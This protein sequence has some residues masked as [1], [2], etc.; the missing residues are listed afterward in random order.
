[1]P[2]Y[3]KNKISGLW[4]VRFREASA[5]D[6]AAHQRRLS[7]FKTKK[8][9]Q[10][11]YEDYLA[12]Q[13]QKESA[14]KATEPDTTDMMFSELVQK[15]LVFEK[16]RI[17]ESSFYDLTKKIGNKI[18]PYFGCLNVNEITPVKILEWQ[19]TL[20][21]Y[22]YRYQKDIR[23]HLCSIFN[24]AEKYYDVRNVMKKVDRPRNLEGKKEMLFWSPEEAMTCISHIPKEDYAALI[25]FLYI[26][27]CRRGEALALTWKDIDFSK[28]E[29]KISKSV[30]FKV[31]KNG[32]SYDITT[33]KNAGSNRSIYLPSFFLEELKEYKDWQKR[34]CVATTFV[35]G[36]SDPLPPTTIERIMTKAAND[37][38]VK[39]IRIHDL[40]H[41]CASFLIHKGV[42]IVAVSRRLGHTS[43]EQTLN[44]YSHM[45]PD[46]QTII[47][48]TLDTLKDVCTNKN[49]VTL[50]TE[51][52]GE[53]SVKF[54][55]GF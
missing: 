44:T 26:S 27:G 6:G 48:N 40:R 46:D 35:F 43:I 54:D 51:N 50:G 52:T 2:S 31:G 18:L 37:S 32:K 1:M 41:S 34:N 20:T 14:P 19:G 38:G 13:K 29:V 49:A 7:G 47:L 24:F 53:K 25:K 55:C 15:F 45:M 12:A 3:E 9:A 22:S 33:P 42:S 5:V 28:G 36:G 4:S 39:R 21:K 30:A 17:K 8:E 16:S 11:G 10:Y 23:S